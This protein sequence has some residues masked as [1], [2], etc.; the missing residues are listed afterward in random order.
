MAARGQPPVC[1]CGH[2]VLVFPAQPILL[3]FL[4]GSVNRQFSY[5]QDRTQGADQS[6]KQSFALVH[7]ASFGGQ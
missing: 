7:V 3:E 5:T 6:Q 2:A 4:D 1:R